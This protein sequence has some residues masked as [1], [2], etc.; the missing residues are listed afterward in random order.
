MASF[1]GSTTG[2]TAYCTARGITVPAGDLEARLIVASEWLDAIYRNSFPGVK[3]GGRE[4]EREWP[5][6]VASDI[7]DYTI[8]SD[9]VPYEVDYATYEAAL[10]SETLSVNYTPSKYKQAAVNG[11]V[12]VTYASFDNWMDIQTKYAKVNEW[13]SSILISDSDSSGLVGSVNRV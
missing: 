5:R 9:S 6:T 11:A 2:F 1:Y 8:P 4:Q 7:Y 10:H 13:L 12:S 3:T